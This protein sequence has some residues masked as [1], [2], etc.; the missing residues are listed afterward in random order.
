MRPDENA[1]T[2]TDVLS[3]CVESRRKLEADEIDTFTVKQLS[4][5]GLP[6]EG[7]NVTVEPNKLSKPTPKDFQSMKN[8]SNGPITPALHYTISED[9]TE[10]RENY[11]K[12]HCALKVREGRWQMKRC[13][14]GVG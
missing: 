4:S 9:M 3:R 1:R 7:L 2:K 10:S 8:S 6:S 11:A 13:F 12:R 5:S 14:K